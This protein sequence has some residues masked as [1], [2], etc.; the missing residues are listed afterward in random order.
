M[1]SRAEIALLFKQL[2]FS[3]EIDQCA[4]RTGEIAERRGGEQESEAQE[5][6][7]DASKPDTNPEEVVLSKEDKAAA[8][9]ERYLARKRK[10]PS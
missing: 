5:G 7:G 4:G 1:L 2:D 10:A 8:A 9:R 3:A 6:E